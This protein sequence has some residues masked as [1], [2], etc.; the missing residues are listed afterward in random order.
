MRR[1][2]VAKD[3]PHIVRFPGKGLQAQGH[4]TAAPPMAGR[5]SAWPGPGSST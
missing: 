5:P 1:I 3:E 4:A 2:I